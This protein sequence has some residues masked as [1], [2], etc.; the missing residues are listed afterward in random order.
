MH[1][2]DLSHTDSVALIELYLD[3]L[4]LDIFLNLKSR[5]P[6]FI[7]A[8]NT[9]SLIQYF[10]PNSVTRLRHR[11]M[12]PDL[13]SQKRISCF[14]SEIKLQIEVDSDIFVFKVR[15]L[16]NQNWTQQTFFRKCRFELTVKLNWKVSRDRSEVS[17]RFSPAD[18]EGFNFIRGDVKTNTE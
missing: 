17:I 1:T 12:S 10:P 6:I 14:S 16:H 7:Q 5:R 13:W 15:I 2:P 18:M 3:K 8:I 11:A 9:F 4:N